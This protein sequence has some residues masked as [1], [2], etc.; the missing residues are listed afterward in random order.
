ML[1]RY[2]LYQQQWMADLKRYQQ[3]RNKKAV[4]LE[5]RFVSDPEI[6]KRKVDAADL[7]EPCVTV[8]D[9]VDYSPVR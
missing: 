4:E 2:E 9:R 7:D 5:N 8:M 3:V 1:D 6:I